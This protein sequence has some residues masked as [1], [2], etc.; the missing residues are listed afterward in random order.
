MKDQARM[1]KEYFSLVKGVIESRLD[2]NG[3]EWSKDT[4]L[5]LDWCILEMEA[6]HE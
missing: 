1:A 4:S 2:A 6:D 5:F 3:W